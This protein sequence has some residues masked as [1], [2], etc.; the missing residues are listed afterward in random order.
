V[1]RMLWMVA[2][3]SS[4]SLIEHNMMDRLIGGV[5]GG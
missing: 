5:E 2:R 4:W 3:V 1:S